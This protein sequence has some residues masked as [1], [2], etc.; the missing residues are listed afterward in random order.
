MRLLIDSHVALWWLEDSDLIGERTR[1]HIT[2]ADEAYFSVV[3]P[4]ELGIKRASGKL[5]YPD[6]LTADL[7]AGGFIELAITG[8]H[9]ETASSLPLHHRDPFDRMMIAQA[10]LERLTIVTVDADFAKYDIEL[11]DARK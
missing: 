7:R 2:H 8:A 11:L 6:S 5:T 9:A 4:W 3:T 1:S 10:Q